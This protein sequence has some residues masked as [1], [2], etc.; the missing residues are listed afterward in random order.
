MKF[1]VYQCQK[2]QDYFVVTDESHLSVLTE[3]NICPTSGDELNKIGEYDEMGETRAAFD[4]GL[5]KRSIES[6]GFYRF[7][8][9]SFDPVAER[10]LSMHA[11]PIAPE[12]RPPPQEVS[13]RM[14]I[15]P[16]S[17]RMPVSSRPARVFPMS[18]SC[19]A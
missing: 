18:R 19:S 7:E 12:T 13:A 9:K 4:E 17:M 16:M 2:D 11:L 3:R 14:E 15:S 6:Q 5:A 8:A 10:P 1:H